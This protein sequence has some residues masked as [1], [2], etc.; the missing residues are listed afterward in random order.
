MFTKVA[1]KDWE[2]LVQKQL[3]TED[4]YSLLTKENLEGLKVNPYYDAVDKPLAN[5]PKIEESTHLVAPYQESLKEHAF[6]FLLRQNVEGLSEKAIFVEQADILKTLK[7]QTDNQ[8]YA[9]IDVFDEQSGTLSEDLAQELLN[10]NFTRNIAIDVALHQNSGA[11]IYQQLGIALAKTKELVEIFGKDILKK[12]IIRIAVGSNYFFELSKIR[13]LKLVY[14]QLSKEF[15]LDEIPYV[16]AETTLRN[17]SKADEENNLIRATLELAAAMIG[18]ADAV[19]ANDYKLKDTTPLSEEIAFKQQIVLAYESI[20]NVFD[21]ASNGSYFIEDLTQQIA[22]QSWQYFLDIEEN[23]GYLNS[24]KSGKIQKDIYAQAIAEQ[25]WVE[26]GKIKLIGVN[27]YPQ[28]EKKQ[29]AESLYSDKEI[30]PVRLA[31]MFE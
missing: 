31:Q 22:E 11:V 6:A 30:T 27:L 24:L 1:L 19:F 15:D 2:Q 20:I 9:L 18:G 26:T 8:Y 10:Q 25:E 3:K 23:G 13:A 4:I 5:L 29:N 7:Y 28:L 12:L 17:K 21:D 16:F 14:N